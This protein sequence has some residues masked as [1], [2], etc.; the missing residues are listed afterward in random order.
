MNERARF[1]VVYYLWVFLL[2]LFLDPL[3]GQSDLPFHLG[4]AL[5]FS[6]GDELAAGPDQHQAVIIDDLNF[7]P[8]K[9]QWIGL[10]EEVL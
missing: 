3:I 8:G 1:S 2:I 6:I 9:A 4:G 5:Y 10:P 7:Q